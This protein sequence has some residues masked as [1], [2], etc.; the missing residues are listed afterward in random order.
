MSFDLWLGRLASEKLP[1]TG[2]YRLFEDRPSWSEKH[3]TWWSER[4]HAGSMIPEETCR[5]L[6]AVWD[7]PMNH[8]QGFMI[9]EGSG[10]FPKSMFVQMCTDAVRR[11]RGKNHRKLELLK[12][13]IG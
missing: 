12:P 7:L 2:E 11:L 8:V 3:G 6:H 10:T 5:A 13:P 9:G 4:D 1:D